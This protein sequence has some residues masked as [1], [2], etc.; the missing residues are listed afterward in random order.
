MR[1]TH[2]FQTSIYLTQVSMEAVYI[3]SDTF[4]R[5]I[6][7]NVQNVTL[8][9]ILRGGIVE[10]IEMEWACCH[11]EGDLLVSFCNMTD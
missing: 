2:F 5:I 1:Q 4:L 9:S 3:P 11:N 10:R 8:L 6:I 7:S